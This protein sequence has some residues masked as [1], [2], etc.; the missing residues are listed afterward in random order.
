MLKPGGW[1]ESY[2]PCC[3]MISDDGSVPP[4]SAMTEWNKFFSEGGKRMG[5]SCTPVEDR[6]QNKGIEAAGFVEIQT[7]EL[8]VRIRAGG[9]GNLKVLE[10]NRTV[11]KQCRSNQYL[12]HRSPSA[13]GPRTPNSARLADICRR[14]WSRIWTATF[15]TLPASSSTGPRRRSPCTALSSGARCAPA[16]STHTS[17]RGAFGAESPNLFIAQS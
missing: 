16:S 1:V 14:R 7:K 4:N 6:L 8:K 15:S 9:R 2:E 12:R 13:D 11:F 17:D 10:N 5:N 3:E